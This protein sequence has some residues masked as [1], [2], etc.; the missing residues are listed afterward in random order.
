M[1]NNLCACKAGYWDNNTAS[2]IKCHYSCLTCDNS[3]SCNTCDS[4]KLRYKI[5]PVPIEGSL[6]LCNDKTYDN[7]INMQCVACSYRCPSCNSSGCI[8]CDP[9]TRDLSGSDCLC[10]SRH[11]D[12]GSSSDCK[13]CHYSCLNCTNLSACTSC[14]LT[15]NR[16]LNSSTQYCSCLT[17]SYDVSV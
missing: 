12:D 5:D 4:T 15:K 2:C 8:T 17:S 6:C 13:E 9:T 11:F 10:K 3:T 1:K 14:D 16:T 7:G